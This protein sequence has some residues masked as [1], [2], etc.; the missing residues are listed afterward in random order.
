VHQINGILPGDTD[1]SSAARELPREV[2]WRVRQRG[3]FPVGVVDEALSYASP[4][5]EA[6]LQMS[7]DAA[8]PP[9]GWSVV[10]VSRVGNIRL[11]RQLSPDKLTGRYATKYLRAANISSSGLDLT[12]VLEMDFTAQ[13]R[14]IYALRPGDIVLAEASGSPAHVG[15]SAMW[16][17]DA[18]ATFPICCFQNTVIRFRP[19]CI[20]PRFA[21]VV[22]HAWAKSGI[23]ADA[24]RGTGIQHLGARRLNSLPFPVP[25]FE[26]QVR[27][28]NAV[29]AK[30]TEIDGARLALNS[31]LRAVSQQLIGTYRAVADGTLLGP[32]TEADDRW[33]TAPFGAT[34]DLQLGLQRSP[35]RLR[36]IS[37]TPYLRAANVGALGLDLSV[38]VFEMDFSPAELK[39]Y[40]LRANDVIIA[41]ASGSDMQVGRA[42]ICTPDVDGFG[43][44]NTVIRYRAVELDP[45]F[46]LFLLRDFAARGVFSQLARGPLS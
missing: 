34:G 35:D 36:G 16:T 31:A 7:A 42:A 43:F 13:E 37:A 46:A 4:S 20:E 23:F 21:L 18:N 11:G 25:P 32:R 6:Q 26:E 45:T 29:D 28:A 19:H 38:G 27:I 33:H 44:Q 30:L 3:E 39:R 14:A 40:A 5:T 2:G 22:F 10:P 15:R 17:E 9:T 41:E 1:Y 8:R 24:A 12:D